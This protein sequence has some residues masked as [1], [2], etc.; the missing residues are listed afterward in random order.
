MS[1]N[2]QS[3][4]DL[5][6]RNSD[7]EIQD[8]NARP[9]QSNNDQYAPPSADPSQYLANEPGFE[10]M[11]PRYS[12]GPDT[13]TTMHDIL[14]LAHFCA[15]AHPPY[16]QS[17]NDKLEADASWNEV[18]NWLRTHT[19]TE[20]TIAASQ[21]DESG[22]TALH[23]A[24]QNSPP[25]DVID[26]IL[27]IAGE[28]AQWPDSFGW[29][30]IHY[31][32]AY[33]ASSHVIKSLAE[34]YPESKTLV[35]RKGRTPLHFALGT[36]NAHSADVVMILSNTGAASYPDDNGMLP[37]HYACAY[38]AAE[39]CLIVLTD[40]Y[41]DAVSF[42]DQRFRT[43]LHFTLSNAGRPAAAAAVRLLLGLN[44]DLV[45]AKDGSPL[46]MKVLAE[47][48][49]LQSAQQKEE[50]DSCKACL[51][52]LIAAHPI[53]TPDFFTALQQL[54]DFLKEIAVVMRHVQELLNYKI[55]ERFCTLILML[56]FYFQFV[57]IYFYSSN[58]QESIEERF[59][60]PTAVQVD[61]RRLWPLYLGA[62]Y[63][64]LREVI[65]FLSLLSMGALRSWAYEP[66]SWLNLLYVLV[67]YFWTFTMTFG[68]LSPVEFRTG[69]SLST[70]FIW[71][72]F[73]SYLRNMMID[74]A[75][76]AGGVFHVMRRLAAFLVCLMIILVAFSR[77]FYTLYENTGY[78]K[79]D[80]EDVITD[81]E[82]LIEMTC[83]TL[84]IN[85]WC[86]GWDSFLSVYTM[87]LGEVDE[88]QFQGN[89]AATV[90]FVLFM[91]LVVIL[92]ANVLI[93]IVTDSYKV[94]QDQRAA[95]VFWTNRLH[96]IAQ[97]DAIANGPW[98][99]LLRNALGLQ[100]KSQN[101][102]S[103]SWTN[104][105]GEQYWKNLM[106]IYEDD[107][108]ATTLSFE[109]FIVS[110]VRLLA[111][112]FVIPAWILL[113]LITLGWFW[114]PQIR[115][116]IFTSAIAKHSSET[117]KEEEL[118]SVQIVNIK[119]ELVAMG[120]ELRFELA[121]D[122]TQIVQTK[123]LV[124]ERKMAINAEMKNIQ[125]I[126]AMLFEQQGNA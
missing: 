50:R 43:P 103:S 15:L 86:D 121:Q 48:A 42:M 6:I 33:A 25:D 11:S 93:A 21:R 117:A 79:V 58:I 82:T 88:T 16:S 97:M 120:E 28:M 49:S 114:P 17:D 55:A 78:C 125:R 44:R 113:G 8:Y 7:S 83:G 57:V 122:R 95:I 60:D 5:W 12:M 65:N 96:F 100:Q 90:L 80:P 41:P 74:F 45:N 18:R 13:S 46:P 29:L 109:Y 84:Q 101:L 56:D 118:R 31:A 73:L 94:I 75:V 76:F 123:S 115:E 66:S 108:N 81:E 1:Y 54:P 40:A 126:V 39:D 23:M 19:A 36:T 124:A 69:A 10:E 3:S 24:C 38:G 89:P 59:T 2:S 20:V 35:D 102:G 27:T 30:P 105:L 22:K 106:D 51:K 26:V 62:T 67:I 77:M 64:F 91:F 104:L 112:V 14:L 70:I 98:R 110:V 107:V 72:K 92:L 4:V 34:I 99:K 61:F 119:A 32:C 87:L 71:T 37:L 116:Y 85:Q 47:F 63:F 53:P 111:F 9:E 68:F 52:H